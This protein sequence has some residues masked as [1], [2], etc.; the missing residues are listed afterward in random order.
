M[1]AEKD[2]FVPWIERLHCEDVTVTVMREYPGMPAPADDLAGGGCPAGG[3]SRVSDPSHMGRN[4][5]NTQSG[6]TAS[7]GV[8]GV[9]Q[10]TPGW[11]PLKVS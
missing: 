9:G 10:G 6:H 5:I 2:N 1:T 3:R 4:T 7:V 8:V 11:F